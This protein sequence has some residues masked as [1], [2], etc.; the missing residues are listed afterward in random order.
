V[1]KRVRSEEPS[2]ESKNASKMLALQRRNA[3]V[4]RSYCILGV[5]ICQHKNF[6]AAGNAVLTVGRVDQIPI[7]LLTIHL[8]TGGRA[9]FAF[10]LALVQEIQGERN[11]VPLWDQEYEP[12]AENG[13]GP[14]KPW[15]PES[16][17]Q[18]RE[19]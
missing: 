2:T 1:N 18:H 4:Y 11:H 7:A 17:L 6:K 3:I 14:E 19:K 12:K 9:N 15:S 5:T 13:N 16:F 10:A 8:D